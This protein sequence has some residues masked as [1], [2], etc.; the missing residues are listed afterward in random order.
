MEITPRENRFTFENHIINE[1]KE[2][3]SDIRELRTDRRWII[4]LLLGLLGLM[5]FFYDKL[6]AKIDRN[7]QAIHEIDKKLDRLEIEIKNE[8]KDIL[9]RL[10][11]K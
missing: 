5:T 11:E 7:T 3:K 2:L 8:L 6:D 10:P 4:G 1:L 9:K